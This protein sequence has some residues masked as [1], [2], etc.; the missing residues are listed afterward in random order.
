MIRLT[1]IRLTREQV[2][3]VDKLAVEQ[4]HI[5][6][7]VLM[8]NAAI[9]AAECGGGDDGRGGQAGADPMRRWE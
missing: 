9:A 8:E 4:Y 7:V 5:P 2:R 1:M 6:G 3:R